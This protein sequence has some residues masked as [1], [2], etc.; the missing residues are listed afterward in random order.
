MLMKNNLLRKLL[1][2]CS[3]VDLSVMSFFLITKMLTVFAT[4]LF[5]SLSSLFC[6]LASDLKLT[7]TT[8]FWL[9]SPM[10]IAICKGWSSRF[11]ET[12]PIILVGIKQR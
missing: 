1:F 10:S 3:V 6:F 2:D 8:S 11:Y 9:D 4:V 12:E 5:L 7:M